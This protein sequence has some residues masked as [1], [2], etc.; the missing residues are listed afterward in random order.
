[1]NIITTFWHK[2]VV[3][4]PVS[5]LLIS[6]G[7][8]IIASFGVTNF[9]LDAS[10]DSLTLE[11]DESLRYYRSTRADYGSDDFLVITYTPKISMFAD[12][13]LARLKKL[14]TELGKINNVKS[15][16]TLLDVPLI[17]SP[18]IGLSEL[19]TGVRYLKDQ[20]T[21]KKLAQRE[22]LNSPIYT[23]LIISPQGKTT[24]LQ[25]NFI[26]DKK[27][28]NLS[29]TR[30]K[31]RQIK[32]QKGL[33]QNEQEQLGRVSAD[34]KIQAKIVQTEQEIIIKKVRV[35]LNNYRQDVKLFL[36]G[37]PMIVVDSINFI[38]DD[39]STFGAAVLGF[40]ILVLFLAFKQPRWIIMPLLSCLVVVLIMVGLLGHLGWDVTVVSSNFIS[41]LLI[42]T[43]SIII[44]LIV[45]FNE[46][47]NA[48]PDADHKEL[49]KKT[50]SAKFRPSFY[51]AITTIVA[52][53]SLL[54]SGIRP[55]IDFG[56]MMTIGI[57][58]SFIVA[59][60]FFPATISLLK[61]PKL[62]KSID[63]TGKV[64][65]AFANAV[66]HHKAT[67][68]TIY[69]VLIT[70]G[71]W[72]VANLTVENR[73]IDYYKKDTDI[74]QGMLQIDK[75]LG[76]TTPMDVIIDAPDEFFASKK[77][78]DT[79][80]DKQDEPDEF[81][82]LDAEFEEG[83]D[84][85]LVSSSYW[86]NSH[87]MKQIKKIHSFLE[88]Q[89]EIGKVLSLDTTMQMLQ[90]LNKNQE[91]D[92]FFMAVIYKKTPQDLKEQLFLP[93]MRADA[94]QIRFSIRIYE[95]D[96]NLKRQDLLNRIDE[97]LKTDLKLKPAQVHLTGM[98]VLYN[99]ML[100]SLFG[101]QIKTLGFVFLAI[102]IM[103]IILFKNIKLALISIIPNLFSSS[104]ILGTMG[105]FNIPLD[106][107]TITIAAI[108]IG[109]G[110]DDTIH[111][112]DRFNKEFKKDNNYWQTI[113][114]CH[115][116]IGKALYYTTL[117]I[118]LGFSIL[119][120]SN[121]VPTIYFGILTGLAMVVALIANL[122]LLPLLIGLFKPLGVFVKK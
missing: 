77:V 68:L 85:S 14:K 42:I 23:N 47:H 102:L 19:E 91:V 59:F 15:V 26:K 66:H 96:K 21:D 115:G 101:S 16:I 71:I 65:G 90:Q 30:D 79:K 51:T 119:V 109:I 76:G 69:A 70:V 60:S 62:H 46:F 118:T 113:S 78:V 54:F 92:D 81:D 43:L 72:G 27:L 11:S 95:S 22:L 13:N 9:K 40:I 25:I 53:A 120:L 5:L 29:T 116:S 107:M 36:G 80:P 99:N 7:L 75:E 17:Q 67:T 56:W 105:I 84:N 2:T 73:F 122:T 50:I 35:I 74:Y 49:I 117:T 28:D 31:L 38:K 89:P 100:Q 37:V 4:K 3:S 108:A 41:L 12:E 88:S 106:I 111:Y 82:D 44:H 61:A 97:F 34:Y 63:F 57:S 55:V 48:E 45:Q 58:I 8:V 98:V 114:R 94:N 6:I 87:K 24:A 18:P 112:V 121:F 104:F 103:F 32:Y 10:G 33:N 83:E 93:Y 64:T 86:F 52:F 1:M 39:I 110:V 20:A